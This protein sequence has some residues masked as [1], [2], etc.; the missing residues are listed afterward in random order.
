LS[1]QCDRDFSGGASGEDLI[2]RHTGLS[3]IS[4]GRATEMFCDYEDDDLFMR[5]PDYLRAVRGSR[6]FK[7]HGRGQEDRQIFTLAV[8]LVADEGF[9]AAIRDSISAAKP[10]DWMGV[11]TDIIR[12]GPT[13]NIKGGY[14]HL[15]TSHNRTNS[16]IVNTYGLI[17]PEGSVCVHLAVG[18]RGELESF[19]TACQEIVAS[20]RLKASGT[21]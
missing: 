21:K 3:R 6:A 18:G 11:K 12:S 5:I 2:D 15:S 4:L 19:E 17:F 20:I 14:E 8:Q 16:D 7:P 9:A 13:A 1:H 10:S